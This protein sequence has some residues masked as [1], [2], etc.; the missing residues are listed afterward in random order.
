MKVIILGSNGMLGHKM[1]QILSQ[2]HEVIGTV[3][4][5]ASDY[6]HHQILSK[7]TIIGNIN[8]NKIVTIQNAIETINP[9]VIINCIG[10][11]KQLP[12][13]QDP[14][15][16]I[17][18]N[19]LF[20]HQVAQCCR[21]GKIRFIHMSTDCIFS[22]KT[23]NYSEDDTPDAD[24]L[25]GRTKYLGEVT[26]PGCL[27]IRTS[28]IGRE[29]GTKHGLVEWFLSQEGGV[30]KGFTSAIFSG[31]TTEML[32]KIISSLLLNYP[33]LHGVYH[34]AS[35]P[36]SKHD[37]LTRIQKTYQIPITIE[38]DNTVIID[39]S[40]DAKK[41]RNETKIQIPSWD[42]MIEKMYQDPTQY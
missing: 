9:D 31:L 22:G 18:I 37:L 20:P 40:L 36:V 1:M 23:G 21:K 13:A 3:R 12:E 26:Y 16:S 6:S 27:T 39:R 7:F 15:K 41:F 11:V 17:A 25:Y 24:D 42:T 28:I 30:V 14:L 34:I 35:D 33:D 29:L 8:A 10:I 5:E 38:P 19:A 32:A 2:C 4:G